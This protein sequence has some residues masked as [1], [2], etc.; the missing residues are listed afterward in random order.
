MARNQSPQIANL[1]PIQSTRI[2]AEIVDQILK[3]IDRGDIVRGDKLPPERQLA[4]QLN[5]SRS[6]LREAMTAL[7]VLGIVEIKPG[8]GIYVGTNF[9]LDSNIGVTGE[10][11]KLISRV[12]PLE[13]LEV[14]ILIEPGAA[15]LAA[16]R[17]SAE[18][19]RAMEIAVS[20]M[21]AELKKGGEAW[22]P[23]W[24]FHRA[25]AAA[26][27]NPLVEMVFDSLGQRMENPLW[28]LMRAHNFEMGDRGQRYLMDHRAILDAIRKRSGT[29]AFRAMHAHIRMIQ[30]DLEAD[31]TLQQTTETPA[32]LR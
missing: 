22:Q 26:T 31:E 12:G 14:R 8:V 13:I 29:A 30:A 10:V 6:A 23:D 28:S 16:E 20:Q 25:I 7:E 5:V 27:Q 4:Q 15:Q 2:Y 18:D 17:R 11:A 3:M 19:L 1:Q 24:G 9:G 21:E 32:R